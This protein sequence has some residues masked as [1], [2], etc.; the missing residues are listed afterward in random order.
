MKTVKIGDRV[1]INSRPYNNLTGKIKAF[2]IFFGVCKYTIKLDCPNL[3]PQGWSI[4]PV[5][6]EESLTFINNTI[7]GILINE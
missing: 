6:R 2:E 1:I 7:S 4:E 5:F 3:V